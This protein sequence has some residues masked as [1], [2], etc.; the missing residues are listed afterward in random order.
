MYRIYLALAIFSLVT[1]AAVAQTS[2]LKADSYINS[3]LDISIPFDTAAPVTFIL[4]E[5]EV[6]A[7]D[8]WKSWKTVENFTYGK[9][10]G[11]LPMIAD[12]NSL[13]PFFRDRIVELIDACKAQGIELAIVETFRTHAKQSEY[14]GMGR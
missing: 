6:D 4:E 11:S 3:L 10:R 14:F 8:M 7:E 2:N 1:T 12:L 9:D 13:H 5:T